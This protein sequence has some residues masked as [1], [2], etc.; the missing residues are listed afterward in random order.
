MHFC[1][2]PFRVNGM[3]VIIMH[4]IGWYFTSLNPSHCWAQAS[5]RTEIFSIPGTHGNV[6]VHFPKKRESTRC[7]PQS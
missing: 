5:S 2:E 4:I 1:K 6:P 3:F 7:R